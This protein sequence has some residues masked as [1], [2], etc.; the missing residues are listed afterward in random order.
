M[1]HA[2]STCVERTWHVRM[3]LESSYGHRV[4][5]ASRREAM[6]ERDLKAAGPAAHQS[7]KVDTEEVVSIDATPDSDA[8][9]VARCGAERSQDKSLA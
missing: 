9:A 7:T 5:A 6:A 8:W 3:Y 4:D 2:I 1:M